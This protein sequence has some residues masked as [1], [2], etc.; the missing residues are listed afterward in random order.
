VVDPAGVPFGAL[1]ERCAT[2]GGWTWVRG[3]ASWE[4]AGD[5]AVSL[6]LLARSA[7]VLTLDEGLF[8]KLGDDAEHRALRTQMQGLVERVA[9]AAGR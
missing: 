5:V 4:R 8:V 1:V 7:D 2:E 9:A 3:G 6:G